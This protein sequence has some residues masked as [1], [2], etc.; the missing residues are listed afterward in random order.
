MSRAL[1]MQVFTIRLPRVLLRAVQAAAAAEGKGI[2]QVAREA[3]EAWLRARGRWPP[4]PDA[5]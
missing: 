4:V 1:P 3:I 5:G 2:G